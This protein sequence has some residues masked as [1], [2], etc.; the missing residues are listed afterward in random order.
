MND[1]SS[2]MWTLIT[3]SL[4]VFLLICNPVI[5]ET[6]AKQRMFVM[7]ISFMWNFINNS[8]RY[9]ILLKDRCSLFVNIN[10]FSSELQLLTLFAKDVFYNNRQWAGVQEYPIV[11]NWLIFL[12][13]IVC[14]T[15]G[16]LKG[17][18]TSTTCLRAIVR[19]GTWIVIVVAHSIQFF[20]I[21]T[22]YQNWFF[23]FSSFLFSKGVYH[24][25]F[26]VASPSTPTIFISWLLLVSQNPTFCADQNIQYQCVRDGILIQNHIVF[27]THL[28]Q[29]DTVS[30]LVGV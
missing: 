2:L 9:P 17:A 22:R 8:R 14:E 4:D 18:C 30:L 28:L 29:Q 16:D 11:V 24:V 5:L 25:L 21:L 3:F 7:Y 20:L 27:V 19:E 10:S 12:Y 13:F 15:V 6:Y 1:L 23:F 26:V